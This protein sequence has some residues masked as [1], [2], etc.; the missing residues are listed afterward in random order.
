MVC[1]CVVWCE[2]EWSEMKGYGVVWSVRCEDQEKKACR[3]PYKTRSP[4]RMWGTKHINTQ[5]A[6]NHKARTNRTKPQKKQASKKTSNKSA[7]SKLETTKK[8]AHG[9]QQHKAP[10]NINKIEQRWNIFGKIGN[11]IDKHRTH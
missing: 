4:L 10:A 7:K 3:C 6:S 2:V 5:T 1:E 8:Q 9:N 11:N